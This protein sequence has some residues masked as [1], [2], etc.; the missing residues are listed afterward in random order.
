MKTEPIPRIIPVVNYLKN[1]S[2]EDYLCSDKFIRYCIKNNLEELW[3]SA[4]E[5]AGRRRSYFSS[6]LNHSHLDA[7]D[8]LIIFLNHFYRTNTVVFFSFLVD[9]L[10]IKKIRPSSKTTGQSIKE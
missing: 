10:L 9:L 7:N 1:L 2:I 3:Q 5:E 8:A 6:G 4:I